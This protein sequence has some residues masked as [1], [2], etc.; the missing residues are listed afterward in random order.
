MPNILDYISWRGDLSLNSSKFNELDNMIM[1]RLS[2]LPFE[3][4]TMNDIETIES[5]SKK[6]EKLDKDDF[7]MPNDKNLILKAGNSNRFKNLIVTDYY[8]SRNNEEEKQFAAITIHLGN[9]E[10]YISYIGTDNTL[11][12]WKED[13]NLSFMSH[14]PS[15]TEGLRYIEKISQKY[16]DNMHLGGHSKGGNIAVYSAVFSPKNIQDRIIDV[17]NH[18]GPGFDKSIIETSEYKRIL[19]K[20]HT[21]IPQ[22]SIIGRLLEHEETYK[23]VKSVQKGIMQHD[24][25][26]WQ[27]LGTEFMYLKELTNGSE[28]INKTVRNW[29]KTTTPEQRSNF[30]NVMYEVVSN[31]NVKTIKEFSATRAKNIGIILKTYKNIDEKDK[32]MIGQMIFTFLVAAK[33]SIKEKII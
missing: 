23:I 24:I 10:I 3:K 2:Y 28:V 19:S 31:T 7:N 1:S 5:I 16:S 12:G 14:I 4:I 8:L 13:F 15:Q 17:T 6:F 26:S 22:S 9:D 33:E 32:K 18:D 25:Y 29:L 20:I 11:V 30:I 21:F 27:L